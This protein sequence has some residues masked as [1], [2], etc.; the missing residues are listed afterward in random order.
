MPAGALD[1]PAIM[2]AFHHDL[3]V[4]VPLGVEIV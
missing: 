2:D 4:L 1:I 3:D